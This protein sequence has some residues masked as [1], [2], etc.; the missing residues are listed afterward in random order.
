MKHWVSRGCQLMRAHDAAI[1]SGGTIAYFRHFS[2]CPAVVQAGVSTSTSR[3]RHW[4]RTRTT[5][6]CIL[7]SFLRDYILRTPA[8]SELSDTYGR[9]E[10]RRIH[11]R[12]SEIVSEAA[13]I[14]IVFINGHIMY[15]RQAMTSNLLV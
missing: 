7:L 15:T 12:F 5:C 10:S 13:K 4:H 1:H 9:A 11:W 3:S 6:E 14:L 8:R 2:R